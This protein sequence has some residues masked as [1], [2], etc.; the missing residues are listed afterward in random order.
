MYLGLVLAGATPQILAQAA[1]AKQFS[2]KD[3]IEVEDN[4]DKKP[5]DS[6]CSKTN[7]TSEN[8]TV[9][10]LNRYA[11]V[12]HSF[13]TNGYKREIEDYEIKIRLKHNLDEYDVLSD[14]FFPTPPNITTGSLV[15]SLDKDGASG[16]FGFKSK[17]GS[18]DISSFALELQ[19][20]LTVLPSRATNEFHKFILKNTQITHENNQVFIVSRLPRAGLDSLLAS[21]AK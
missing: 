21:D 3:E 12:L 8:Q 15:F 1:T 7:E 18:F 13:L 20:G 9:D 16:K 17:T 11:V 10:L 4:L 5:E 19:R 2:V 14:S 6:P